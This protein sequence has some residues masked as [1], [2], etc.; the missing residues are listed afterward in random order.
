MVSPPPAAAAPAVVK[1][2]AFDWGHT[3]MDERR[4]RHVPLD[5][6]PAHLMPGVREALSGLASA[7]GGVGEHA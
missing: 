2:L 6:R 7:A 4:D 1:V 5:D 3:L